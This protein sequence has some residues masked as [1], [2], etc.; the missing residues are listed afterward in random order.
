MYETNGSAGEEKLYI[1]ADPK[2]AANENFIRS[3]EVTT[4]SGCVF[5]RDLDA[6]SAGLLGQTKARLGKVASQRVVSVFRAWEE[7]PRL[8][9]EGPR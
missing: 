3:S 7:I 4:T 2:D 6:S 8:T 9:R 1:G 5:P